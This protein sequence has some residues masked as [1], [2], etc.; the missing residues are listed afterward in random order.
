MT[1]RRVSAAF[2]LSCAAA[3]GS[4]SYRV[5]ISEVSNGLVSPHPYTLVGDTLRLYAFEMEQGFLTAEEPSASSVTS[6]AKFTWKTGDPAIIAMIAPGVFVMRATGSTFI[7][8]RT[9]RAGGA[10]TITVCANASV[11][12]VSP[13]NVDL[14]IPR[15]TVT[16]T[17][18]VGPLGQPPCFTPPGTSLERLPGGTPDGALLLQHLSGSRYTGLRPG[19]GQ[20]RALARAGSRIL[21]DTISVIVR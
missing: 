8:A 4:E 16:F 6:P 7:N 5:E 3:C 15:D 9:S 10:A 17:F 1:L 13:D 2:V 21:A 11:L 18:S 12:H 14:T 19:S 20:Y